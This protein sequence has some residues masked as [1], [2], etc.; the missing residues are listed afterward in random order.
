MVTLVIRSHLGYESPG[1]ETATFILIV[2]RA[3]RSSKFTSVQMAPRALVVNEPILLQ[4]IHEEIHMYS[5]TSLIKAC[6]LFGTAIVAGSLFA[7]NVAAEGRPVSVALQVSTQGLNLSTSD[8]A[9]ELYYRLKNAAWV[10]CTRANRV[11]LEPSPNANACSEKSLAEAIRSAHMPLLVQAY[12]ETHSL[13]QAA[14][15][16]IEVPVQMASK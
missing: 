12:L 15:H 11:G 4:P 9:R 6:S 3:G 2:V 13:G 10:A 7:G 16:G 14:A 1:A 8:G 5:K